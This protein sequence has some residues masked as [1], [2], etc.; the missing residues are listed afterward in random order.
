M[1]DVTPYA[2]ISGDV[3]AP[4]PARPR[5]LLIATGLACVAAAMGFSAL[6]GIYVSERSQVIS[7]G[8]V[9]LPDGVVIPLTQ[10]NYMGLTMMFSTL[11]VW[12]V[13]SA[14]KN[15]DRGNALVA[16]GLTTMFGIAF[17]AQSAFLLDLME[18]PASV[19]DGALERVVFFYGLIGFHT[20]LA[21]V[22]MVYLFVMSLRGVGG[23]YSSK[24]YEGVQSAAIVWTAMAALYG[25]MWYA[26][27]IVK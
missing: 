12:W 9:W 14:I 21:I 25:V 22:A 16:F 13:V 11:T 15:N 23:N 5:V 3:A 18:M 24:D 10:P 20:V 26:I 2:R 8:D 27:Y 7:A 17:I 1:T 19:L 6:L 4:A